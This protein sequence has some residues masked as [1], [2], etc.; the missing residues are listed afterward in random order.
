MGVAAQKKK[1]PRSYR[2]AGDKPVSIRLGL[3]TGLPQQ[4]A[5][6]R[7]ARMP[8]RSA[9]LTPRQR[10]M[11]Q[12]LV[13]ACRYLDDIYWRQSDPDGLTLR[14][15]RDGL[16]AGRKVAVLGFARSGIALARFLVDKHAR[17]MGRRVE[18][19]HP[20]SMAALIAY[21]WPGN[22][23]ELENVMERAVLLAEKGVIGPETIPLE[24]DDAE[25]W[26]FVPDDAQSLAE[27]KRELRAEAVERLERLFLLKALRAAA[28]NVS[29]AARA[30]DMQRPNFHALMRK[31]GITRGDGGDE[32][33]AV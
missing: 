29:E 10:K 15:V 12:K 20:D 11:V 6:W 21:D 28:W 13:E 3:A 22:V 1:A 18:R 33:D 31:H 19:I 23:R 5:K 9:G 16:L 25:R 27:Y 17:R 32:G 8:F 30:V 4:L 7:V 2:S 14:A 26:D 24:G